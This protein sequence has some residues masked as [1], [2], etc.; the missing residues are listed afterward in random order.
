[1]RP[2]FDDAAE[3]I[4]EMAELRKIGS[5]NI[6][7]GMGTRFVVCP[8]R[9][10]KIKEISKGSFMLYDDIGKIYGSRPDP[11]LVALRT[12]LRA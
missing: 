11:D 6:E 2:R 5:H 8:S 12:S 10:A 4:G 7:T 9:A 1:M 3:K